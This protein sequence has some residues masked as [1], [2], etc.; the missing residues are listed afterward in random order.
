MLTDEEKNRAL[1]FLGYPNLSQLEQSIQLGIPAAS[2]PLFLV[3]GAF[4][5]LTEG[6]CASVREDL[7]QL[8][9]IE[10]QLGSARSRMRAS[11]LGDLKLNGS[12]TAMLRKE[13][14]FW[15]RRLADDLAV[16]PNP[17]AQAFYLGFGGGVN[18][19]VEG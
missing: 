17:Y 1:H 3:L 7:C 11:A 4:D 5:R 9:S 13:L 14:T 12:E 2:Q 10:N 8:E 19:K 18:A 6:G 16:V 15:T